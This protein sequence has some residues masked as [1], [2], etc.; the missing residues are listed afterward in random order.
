MLPGRV[1]AGHPQAEPTGQA[2]DLA[3]GDPGGSGPVGTAYLDHPG[4]VVELGGDVHGLAGAF[5]VQVDGGGKR[6]GGVHHQQVA[7]PQLGGE[8]PDP[9]VGEQPGPRHEHLH[10][11]AGE[12][13]GLGRGGG[14]GAGRR[15]GSRLE[16]R[17]PGHRPTPAG[18][19]ISAAR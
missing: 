5:P 12:A 7:G 18:T 17:G 2:Q 10:R 15:V 13:A 3:L 11:V 9:A 1:R 4:P 16:R 8:V 14:L 19:A 6:G